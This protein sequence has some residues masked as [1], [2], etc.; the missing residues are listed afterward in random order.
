MFLALLFPNRAGFAK[1]E[2]PKTCPLEVGHDMTQ[3]DCMIHCPAVRGK[4]LAFLNSS[5]EKKQ[6]RFSRVSTSDFRPRIWRRHVVSLLVGVAVS[7]VE[8]TTPSPA[9]Y[10]PN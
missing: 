2:S 4:R 6:I 8:I 9:T 5:R 3:Q 1:L 7:E 10:G